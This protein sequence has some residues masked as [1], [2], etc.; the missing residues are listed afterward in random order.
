MRVGVELTLEELLTKVLAE[1][2]ELDV[3]GMPIQVD[4]KDCISVKVAGKDVDAA[5]VKL[6]IKIADSDYLKDI[7]ESAIKDAVDGYEV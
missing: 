3:D 1:T 7:N 4:Y 6:I 2:L 5:K